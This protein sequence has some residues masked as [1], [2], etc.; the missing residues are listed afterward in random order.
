MPVNYKSVTYYMQLSFSER[1]IN[2]SLY[3]QNTMSVGWLSN[4]VCLKKNYL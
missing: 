4:N 2:D 1:T 3:Y